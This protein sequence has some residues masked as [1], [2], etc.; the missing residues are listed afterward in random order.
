[1]NITIQRSL[2]ENRLDGW[3]DMKIN[4][5]S[6]EDI[7]YKNIWCAKEKNLFLDSR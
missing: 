7:Y 2:V 1:M 5:S 4:P 6:L 3:V